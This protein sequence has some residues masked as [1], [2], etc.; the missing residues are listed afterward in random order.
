MRAITEIGESGLER[1]LAIRNTVRTDDPVSPADYVDWRRQ[2]EDMGWWLAIED[3]ADAGAGVAVHGWHSAAGVGRV[4]VFV[5]PGRRGRGHGGAL[6]ETLN[7]WLRERGCSEA[8]SSVRED[9]G[10]SLAWA[11][12]RGFAEVG[13]NSTLVLDLDTVEALDP[14]LPA[15]VEIVT[16]AERPDLT[17]GMYAVYCEAAP[18]IPGEEEEPPELEAWLANDMQGSSDRPEA[19]FMAVSD[20][21]V[22]GYAK[23]SVS[24]SRADVAWHDLTGVLRA[25]RGRGVAGALKRTQIAW[26]K[27]NGYRQL[28]TQNEE[29]N[30]PVQRL[31]R[32][33]GYRPEP[34]SITVRGPIGSA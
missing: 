15:G 17:T 9:D 5:T 4:G 2:A 27:T 8:L 10:T 32:R 13:R 20:G 21:V 18:D 3:G 22:V 23:L 29:R 25:W 24:D 14:A 11:A 33:H 12:R 7:A 1:L 16:W 31:N 30:E 26:A 6:L 34:G 28:K 19:T